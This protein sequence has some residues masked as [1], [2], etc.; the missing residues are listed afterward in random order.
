ME[1]EMFCYIHEGGELVKTAVGS[2]EYK[3]GRT[4]C[5]VVS[6]NI[7]HSEFVSKVYGEL[8]LDSNSIKLEFIVKFDPSCLL[9]LHNDGDIV[10]MFKFNDMFCHVYISQC[11]K[12]G[13]DLICPTRNSPKHM[14]VV[15]TIEDCP[16]KITARAIGDSNIVQVHTFRNV[17]NHC[18]EDVALSQPLVRSTRASLVIDDVIRSTPEY[19]P[20]QICK[21]FV[22]QH[23]IQLT[24][25]QAWKMKEKAKERIYGQPKNY[26]KL[27]PWMCERMLATNPGSSVEWSYSDDDHLRSFLLLIQYLLKATAYDANDSMFPLAFGV[28]SSENYEDWLWFLEK[29]KIVVGNK[30]VIII[31][32]RHPAL[33]RSVPE[34]FGI[35]N[36]AYC[37]RHLKENFSSFLSKHNTRGTRGAVY[38]V[39]PFKNGVFGV[40]IGRALLN[41]DILNRTCTCRGWQMLGIPC[42][43]ATT[44]II[45]I[46]QNVT[47]FVDDCYKYPM[48]ELIYGGSFSSI[49]THDMPTVDDDGLVRFITG[50]VFFSLKPPH[51]KHLPEGQGRS[52]LSLNFKINGLF[53]ALVVICPA[54]TEKPAK[55]LCPKCISVYLLHYADLVLLYFN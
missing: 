42:E 20:R 3:G 33:L 43:H 9:P 50:E 17:H 54:I 32:D 53:I 4:N 11:T 19:Q 48:Q 25:L 44:V 34:M 21:D 13:D 52:A 6:K 26:Y 28:M 14:T 7:S 40:C 35:E 29:L 41:V 18:L 37:Y 8:N 1:E 51:T 23:G 12:C 16:W 2:V 30:E 10:N 5:S 49:E 46:G 36:H 15:C 45:S 39:T 27:L 31:S 47:D 24:Y 22:R 55:I 38:P